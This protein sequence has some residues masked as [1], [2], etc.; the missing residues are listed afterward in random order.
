MANSEGPNP[1]LTG[2]SSPAPATN[3]LWVWIVLLGVV[4]VAGKLLVDR[5]S[6]PD[7]DPFDIPAVSDVNLDV[8]TCTAE[9]G[10]ATAKVAIT[11]DTP[12][13]YVGLTGEY[14]VEGDSLGSGVGHLTNVVPDQVYRTQVR[15]GLDGRAGGGTC[16]VDVGSVR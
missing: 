4:L 10:F 6:D 13:S 1:P 2:P 16:T 12:M 3:H 14:D 9:H 11:V 8:V 15:Y 7:Q 5:T